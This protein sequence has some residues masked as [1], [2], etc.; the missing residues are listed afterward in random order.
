LRLESGEEAVEVRLE[1][2]L[3]QLGDRRVS[4]RA[5]PGSGPLDALEID[6]RI[7]RVRA[8]R[9]G[10]RVLVWCDGD[11]FEITQG[12]RSAR[13]PAEVAGELAA[14]MPGRVRRIL[15]AEGS[16]VTRGEVIFVLE[17][18]KMEHAIRA[19]RDGVVRAIAPREGEM[20]DAGAILAEME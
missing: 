19:P 8:I 15:V 18:M 2:G 5:I 17:A 14:P 4:V 10:S 11:V 9:D 20:V 3:A 7:A 16:P 12:T 13:R 6:G 1:G